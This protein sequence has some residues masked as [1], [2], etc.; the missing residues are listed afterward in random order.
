[1]KSSPAFG[2]FVGQILEW[3]SAI[4]TAVHAA[5]RPYPPSPEIFTSPVTEVATLS[6]KISQD[7][8]LVLYEKFEGGLTGVP[9]YKGHTG[10]WAVETENDFVVAIGWESVEAHTAWANTDVGAMSINYL[11]SGGIL[12][13]LYHIQ[14]V[15]AVTSTGH[16]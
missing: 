1:M 4:P 6:V 3:C 10:G 9:G 2:P 13:Q 7:E 12:D 15:G 11:T 16:L 5:M 14:T 8:W